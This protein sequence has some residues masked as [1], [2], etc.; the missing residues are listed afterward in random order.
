M[1]YPVINTVC[2]IIKAIRPDRFLKPVR[3]LGQNLFLN[4]YNNIFRQ[5]SLG[6]KAQTL[7]FSA[8][9][10]LKID[11]ISREDNLAIACTI[12]KVEL[13]IAR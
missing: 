11:R 3:S 9:P 2:Q 4:L 12:T 5:P 8:L 1:A 7:V 10:H 6:F 13:N